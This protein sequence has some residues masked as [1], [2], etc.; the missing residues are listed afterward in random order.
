[1][2]LA[3]WLYFPNPF[4]YSPFSYGTGSFEVMDKNGSHG[5][6]NE[7]VHNRTAYEGGHHKLKGHIH[8]RDELWVPYLVYVKCSVAILEDGSAVV[9]E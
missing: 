2:G 9:E 4:K 3:E 8:K 5:V 1:M 6:K 7:L